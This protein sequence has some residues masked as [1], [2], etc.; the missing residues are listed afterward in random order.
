MDWGLSCAYVLRRSF[1]SPNCGDYNMIRAANHRLSRA[2]PT[3]RTS[4]KSTIS[5]RWLS[6]A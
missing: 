3:R 4:N 5:R 1:D 6:M 2:A